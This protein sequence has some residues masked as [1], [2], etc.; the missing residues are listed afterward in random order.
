MGESTKAV[1]V[2]M[3]GTVSKTAVKGVAMV[4]ISPYAKEHLTFGRSH[5]FRD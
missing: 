4:I 1:A 5:G 2:K 3:N